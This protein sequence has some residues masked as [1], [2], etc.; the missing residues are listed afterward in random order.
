[1]I[2]TA[3][4]FHHPRGRPLKPGL[5]WLTKKWLGREIQTRGEGGH[6]PEEDARACMELVQKKLTQPKGWGEFK[7]DF[8]SIFLRM[9]RSGDVKSAVVDHG[10]PGMMHGGKATTSVGC[11][12]DEEVLNGLLEVIPSHQF[13]FGRFMNLADTLGCTQTPCYALFRFSNLLSS[14]QG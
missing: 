10:N 1:V 12:N 3:L 6:D 13:V 5:A 9:G 8:E 11:Q 7:V 14:P 4:I 2:D